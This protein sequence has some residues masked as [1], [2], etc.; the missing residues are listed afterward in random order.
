MTDFKVKVESGIKELEIRTGSVL[1]LK[2]P[3]K[4]DISGNIDSPFR[5]LEQ[6]AANLSLNLV[7]HKASHVL[8]NRDEKNITLIVDEKN[9]YY[10]RIIGKLSFTTEYES[11]EINS[12]KQWE[13]KKLAQFLRLNK[14]YFSDK[15]EAA[16]L[17]KDL[18]NFEA[19]VDKEVKDK[20]DNRAGI[21]FVR[22]QVVQTNLPE[23]FNLQMRIFKGG[24][25]MTFPVEIDIDPY[26]FNCSFV[27]EFAAEMIDGD[28]ES[29]IDG[30]VKEIEQNFP[31][32][33]IIEK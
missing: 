22:R 16:K 31:E 17:V 11:F 30:Q 14:Y 28:I 25:R 5:F 8:V 23:R 33:L 19:K 12:G 10:G 6:R 13:I 3:E 27:S 32:I 29:I 18:M 20:Q 26:S 21:D 15:N 2:E 4:I 1:P 7:D 9:Y 24:E